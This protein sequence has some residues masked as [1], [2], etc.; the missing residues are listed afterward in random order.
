VKN[1]LDIIPVDRIHEIHP[2]PTRH[3]V[4]LLENTH[5][6]LKYSRT[7]TRWAL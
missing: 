7:T 3:R 4:R 5:K 1:D 6:P 2:D